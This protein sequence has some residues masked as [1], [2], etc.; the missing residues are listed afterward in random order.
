METSSLSCL[1]TSYSLFGKEAFPP[2]FFFTSS[3]SH[4]HNTEATPPAEP[5]LV[6]AL[7]EQQEVEQSS[8]QLPGSGGL[9]KPA[10]LL[11]ALPASSARIVPDTAKGVAPEANRDPGAG[12]DSESKV[13]SQ[14]S[15][16]ARRL[17][18]WLLA[19]GKQSTAPATARKKQSHAPVGLEE[20]PAEDK[21]KPSAPETTQPAL[22]A[23]DPRTSVSQNKQEGSAH[24]CMPAC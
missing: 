4:A 8:E 13:Q 7:F 9:P 24:T 19:A 5:D 3:H 6:D 16:K 12:Q 21:A 17:P 18:A 23:K 20:K 11:E 1:Q 14:H 22:E 2:F 10:P 15:S